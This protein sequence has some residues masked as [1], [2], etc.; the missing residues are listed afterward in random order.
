MPLELKKARPVERRSVGLDEKWLQDR[1]VDDPGLLGLGELEIAAREHR[2]PI[3]GRI[4]FLMRDTE[5]ETFYEVEVMLGAL[6][7][8]HVIRTMEYWDI[9]RQRRP[10]FDHRAVIVAEQITSRFFNVLRL[11]NRAVPIIAIQLSAFRLDDTVILHPV[12]V[13][14]VVEEVDVDAVD[15]VEE[16][17][18]AYWEKKSHLTSL[19]MMDKIVASLRTDK[20]DP[21][22]TY[23]RYHVAMRTTG[24]NFCWFHPR[25]SPG[26]CHIEFRVTG[27]T[28]DSVVS[29]LQN[30]G[31]DASPQRAESATFGITSKE[32]EEHSAVITDVLRGA[33]EASRT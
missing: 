17:N 25:K 9:E 7:E 6:D 15:R 4:D 22:L 10:Q 31:I 14:D 32:L 27:E 23:N 3:G 29:S 1:I 2:Q 33:E 20:I 21:K 28:R 18:R 24:R 16:V 11:L 13:L 26:H 5:A 12:T 30:E 19:A 8:S